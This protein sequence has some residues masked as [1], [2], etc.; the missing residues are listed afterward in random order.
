MPAAGDLKLKSPEAFRYI[1]RDMPIV[2]LDDMLT[3]NTTYG[4]DVRLP[5]ML[6]ASIE[7]TPWL[8]G[9]LASLGDS[10]TRDTAGVVDVIQP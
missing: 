6:Y 7:R 3:G 2:D 1:G 8:Q 9:K 5:G 4:I 10:A